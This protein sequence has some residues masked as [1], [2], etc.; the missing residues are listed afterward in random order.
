M[1]HTC[2]RFILYGRH[3]HSQGKLNTVA[4]SQL[5]F[6]ASTYRPLQRVTADVVISK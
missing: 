6:I 4:I 5:K 3:I 2:V 1:K